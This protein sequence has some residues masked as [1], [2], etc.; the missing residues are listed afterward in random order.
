MSQ[1][2][3]QLTARE[4]KELALQGKLQW[5]GKKVV[6]D[7]FVQVRHGF[8]IEEGFTV[9]PK[10]WIS[11]REEAIGKEDELFPLGLLQGQIFRFWEEGGL[12]ERAVFH[13]DLLQLKDFVEREDQI[14]VWRCPIPRWRPQPLPILQLT[15]RTGA[16]AN[17]WMDFGPCGK[18]LFSGEESDGQYWEKDLL[19]TD[20]IK[21]EVGSSKYFC[22]M[23][24]VMKSLLFLLDLGWTL[25]DV[26]GKKII[27]QGA[28]KW[29]GA[30]FPEHLLVSG[31][32][33]Y[34]DF[35]ADAK[36]V[37]G[38]FNRKEKFINLS[39]NAVGLLQIP[40]EWEPL[41]QEE[42]VKEGFAVKKC[43]IGLMQE[44]VPLPREYTPAAWEEIVPGSGFQGKLFDYQ[45]K[46]L[47]FLSYLYRSGFSGLLADEMG[48]GKTLQVIALLS[49]LQLEKPV[50]IVMPVSLLFHWENEF[51]KFL[52]GKGSIL[53]TSYAKLRED[54]YLQSLSYAAVI[55]DEAQ[56]I[57]NPKSKI[58]QVVCQLN[59]PF[60]LALTGT[61]IENRYEDLASIFKFLMPGLLPEQMTAQAIIRKKIA[62]FTLRRTKNEVGLE[63]PEKQEQLILVEWEES[64]RSF[65]DTYLKEKRS[66][67]VQ[68]VTEHGLSSQRMEVLELILRLRQ[69]CCHPKLVGGE[70]EG[71]K[72]SVVCADLEEVV[73]SGR[74][75]ILYSQFTSVLALFKAWAQSQGYKFAYLDGKTQDR[76]LQVDAFQNDP[77][78]PIFL[79][80]LKAGGV[81][82]N[83]Q[84]ADYVFLYDPWWNAAA[85]EQATARAHRVGRKGSVVARKYL[86]R[87]SIEEKILKLQQHKKSLAGALL[88]FEGE[89][90]PIGLE[91]LYDLLQSSFCC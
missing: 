89:V 24:K 49:T 86:M 34:G 26:R 5:R 82:L 32:V 66:A 27:R 30:A 70:Y 77:T 80:S 23:D 67:L 53:L 13:F 40:S 90:G 22:P 8:V 28:A 78:I 63:L 52:P 19:E 3:D 88:E 91:E 4:I 57:K 37:L 87:E 68:K 36:D 55:L 72:F 69:I 16:F 81:G 59:A 25:L 61:P 65:Y 38:S 42:M 56:N 84:A 10:V 44:F 79:M 31:R 64:E 12:K 73:L 14:V 83:L 50:L 35:T 17:L 18:E 7:P 41:A 58:A 47:S 46:G 21:K 1:D 33:Q 60:K 45:M 71:S 15:D 9:T 11:G 85:E 74:K 62:P 51:S 20:F 6:L 76:A 2:L 29:Q 39:D 48:L 54:L 75:V 43:N